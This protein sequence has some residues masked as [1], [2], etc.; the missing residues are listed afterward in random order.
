MRNHQDFRLENAIK[1]RIENLGILAKNFEAVHDNWMENLRRFRHECSLLKLFSNR[2]IM[3]LIILLR[4][5]A[6]PDSIRHRFLKKIFSFK[7]LQHPVE[8]EN[9]YALQCLMHYLRSLRIHRG[10]F[11]D[12]QVNRLYANYQIEASAPIELCLKRLSQFLRDLFGD[13]R[14][15]L[16]GSDSP[17]DYNQQYLVAFNPLPHASEKITLEHQFD[18]QTCCVLLNI[19][20]HRLPATYQILWAS[21]ATIDDIEL[22]FARIRAFPS[23]IFVIMNIDQMHHRL[24]EI[25]FNEQTR[26]TRE[27]QAHGT[28]Y[29]FSRELAN[30]RKGLRE[31]HIKSEWKDPKQTYRHLLSL[32]KSR[33][34][35]L[36]IQIVYGTAGIGKQSLRYSLVVFFIQLILLGK[37]HRINTHYQGQPLTCFSINDRLDLSWLIN[38]LLFFDSNEISDNRTIYFNISIHAPFEILNRALFCLFICGSLKD[39]HSGLTFALPMIKPWRFVIEIP[40]SNIT[41]LSIRDNFDQ[42]LPILSVISSS[43]LVEITNENYPLFIGEEEELVARF[44]EAFEKGTIDRMSTTNFRGGDEEVKFDPIPD[45]DRCRSQIQNAINRYAPH[46]LENKIDQL[47]LTKFLYRRVRY[48]LGYYYRYNQTI[49][50]LG[51]IAMRQMISEASALTRI[52]FRNN[53]FPRIYLLYDPFYSLRLLH[54]DWNQVSPELKSLFDNRDPLMNRNMEKNVDYFV[55]CLSW[56]IDIPCEAFVKI[57]Q[58]AKFI[59]TE[60]FAY[61]LFHVHER[62]LTKLA[63]IIEGDTGVGKTFLLKFYSLLLNSEHRRQNTRSNILPRIVEHSSAFLHEI[64]NDTLEQNVQW[65]NQFIVQIRPLLANV[66]ANRN[67]PAIADEQEDAA[68]DAELLTKIKLSLTNKTS[69]ERVLHDIWKTML[70]TS[71]EHAMNT[72]A[73]LIQALH[74]YITTELANYPLIEASHRL[75][76]LLQEVISPTVDMS[77]EIFEEYLFSSPTRSLYYRLLL[78]PGITEERIIQFMSPISQ[79]ARELPQVELVVFFDEVNTSSCLGL[80]KEMFM[81][82][83]LHGKSLPTNIFFTAAINPLSK[84]EKQTRIHRTDYLVHQLPQSL[85]HLKVIYGPLESRTLSDYIAQKFQMLQYHSAVHEK[86]TLISDYH[87]QAALAKAIIIAHEFCEEKLGKLRS[88]DLF[89]R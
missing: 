64:I 79:L 24:R 13:G 73:T 69:K 5:S 49:K 80:F 56:L 59:L 75:T 77:I 89:F 65:L 72:T 38:S 63:L 22:F 78:H 37:T 11:F 30:T 60:N 26:L 62:K 55:E 21:D 43:N 36:D 54:N 8:E 15:L 6:S 34:S 44:L 47:S 67:P 52:N 48:F 50:Q 31:F 41:Q 28:V 84:P 32:Q 46:L 23:L 16:E 7:D 35:L 29:Y 10:D 25:L 81:D 40:Y 19:F 27:A 2:Q 58:E 33:S 57:L 68:T 17:D 66:D 39:D 18:M 86:S 61:K 88:V 9:Q 45:P 71:I 70:N 53:S 87:F 14:E 20:R 4:T 51:S 76:T 42:I 82:G 3:F 83:T 12:E 74:D 85:E 1:D